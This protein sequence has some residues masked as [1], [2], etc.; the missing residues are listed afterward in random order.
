MGAREEQSYLWSLR[1]LLYSPV[2][3]VYRHRG[4]SKGQKNISPVSART[5]LGG[6]GRESGDF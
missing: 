4:V 3:D 1:A 6:Q 5:I 2:D